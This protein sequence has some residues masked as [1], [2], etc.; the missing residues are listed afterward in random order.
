MKKLF[1]IAGLFLCFSLKTLAQSAGQVTWSAVTTYDDGSPLNVGDVVKFD[2]YRATK[3]DLS[4]AV[5]LTTTSVTGTSYTDS[6]I[7]LKQKYYYF[8]REY[9][10]AGN[11]NDSNVASLN[12]FPPKK[13]TVTVVGQ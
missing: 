9:I 4:D 6:T 8:V 13:T 10:V 3:V 2:V 11:T 12:T 7:A 1:L 5:K